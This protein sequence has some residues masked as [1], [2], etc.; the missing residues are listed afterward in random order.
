M[1]ETPFEGVQSE[2]NLSVLELVRGIEG[3]VAGGTDALSGGV[4]LKLY[5]DYKDY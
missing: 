2:V 3:V 4:R 1:V 5:S